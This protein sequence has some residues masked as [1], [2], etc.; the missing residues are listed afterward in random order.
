MLF[1]GCPSFCPSVIIH[2][3][4][5]SSEQIYRILPTFVY[6]LLSIRS[7][8]GLL[9]TILQAFV[10]EF[11]PLIDVRI[12]FLLN[13]FKKKLTEFHQILYTCIHIDNT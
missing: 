5:I 12:L 1:L 2:F 13:I 7:R 10:I 11:W 9:H 6:A 3:C 8:L 4:S